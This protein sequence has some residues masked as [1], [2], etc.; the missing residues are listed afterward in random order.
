MPAVS[1][2]VGFLSSPEDR[3]LLL[4]PTYQDKV[5]QALFVGVQRFLAPEP[6]A[7][8]GRS[9]SQSG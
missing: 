9:A 4:D 7:E 2:E 5:A 8:E 3:V 6:D 1:V